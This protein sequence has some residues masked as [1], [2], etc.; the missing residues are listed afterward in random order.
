MFAAGAAGAV[1]LGAVVLVA[2]VLADLAAPASLTL[3]LVLVDAVQ[4]AEA[5]ATSPD[6]AF[7]ELLLLPGA[8]AME[9]RKAAGE[10]A[11]RPVAAPLTALPMGGTRHDAAGGATRKRG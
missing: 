1:A 8:G 6:A 4:L 10:P 7:A 9:G 3:A 11:G 2:V 5:I